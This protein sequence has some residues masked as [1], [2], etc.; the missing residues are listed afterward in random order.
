MLVLVTTSRVTRTDPYDAPPF[1]IGNGTSAASLD[2]I[3][4]QVAASL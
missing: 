3:A 1:V 2:V 4:F